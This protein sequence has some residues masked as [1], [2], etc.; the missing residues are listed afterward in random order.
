MNIIVY[1]RC[2]TIVN[3]FLELDL[4]TGDVKEFLTQV[5]LPVIEGKLDQ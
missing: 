3:K 1:F 4:Q 5:V 2:E